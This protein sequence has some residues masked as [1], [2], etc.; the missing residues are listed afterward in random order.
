MPQIDFR[1]VNRVRS[2]CAW[3]LDWRSDV[4]SQIGQ[5]GILEK[6]FG[7]IG[8]GKKFCVEFGAWDGKF[9][10]NTWNLIVNKRWNGVLIEGNLEKFKQLTLNHAGSEVKAI[11][12]YVG[13]EGEN[14]LDSLLAKCGAPADPDLISIDVDGNDWHIWKSLT[15]HRPRVVLIEF[16]PSIPNDVFFVQDPRPDVNHGSSLLAMIE[17][18]KQKGYSL[19]C[20]D[21]WD[22]F[23][24][25]D[26]LFDIF[27]IPDNTIDSMYA[28]PEAETRLFQGFDGTLFTAGTRKLLWRNTEFTFDALQLLPPSMRVY[29]DR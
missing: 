5:D 14:S 9:L 17:L 26:E 25:V 3:L 2:D 6:I 23:F 16:N 15:R 10:S 24:V 29:G 13:L 12:G 28:Y 19:I 18:G 11:R 27:K 22:A 7:V 20:A 8:D 21:C 4:T 1:P